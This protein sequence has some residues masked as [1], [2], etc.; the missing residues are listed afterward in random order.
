MSV[1]QKAHNQL[2]FCSA[3]KCQGSCHIG[4]SFAVRKIY[5]SAFVELAATMHH[6][7]LPPCAGMVSLCFLIDFAVDLVSNVREHLLDFI[8]MH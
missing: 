2:D 6:K 4:K 7:R 8:Q 1:S 5:N 3:E